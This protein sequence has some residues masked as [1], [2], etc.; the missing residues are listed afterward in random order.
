MQY[1]MGMSGLTGMTGITGMSG[2]TGMTGMTGLSGLTGMTGMSGLTSM[3]GMGDM[4]SMMS[5]T[6]M[7]QQY[8]AMMQMMQNLA[9]TSTSATGS[10]GTTTDLSGL[11]ASYMGG[12]AGTDS[13]SSLSS[14]YSQ[15]LGTYGLSTGLTSTD[16]STMISNYFSGASL[17]TGTSM[18]STSYYGDLSSL[19]S[20][21]TGLTATGSTSTVASGQGVTALLAQANSMVGLNENS[22]TAA[23]NQVTKE[24]GIN[25]A[26]TPWC[27]AWAMNLLRDNGVLDLD[28]L[29]NRNYCPTV[30]SWGKTEGI[31]KEGGQYSPQ[32][33]DA[34]LF[35]WDKDG[36][37]DHIGIVE[38]VVNGQVYTIEGNS[39]NSVK[40]NSY[41]LS[42]GSIDGY[43]ACQEQT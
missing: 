33:G 21:S 39:S 26:T 24:S 27:A 41:S 40:K 8:Q 5:M 19:L 10:L 7:Q 12:T 13:I 42:S 9:G 16:L 14:Y 25:C 35:D 31:W 22:D 4:L 36:T 37:A 43:L 3:S 34:I 32:P 28:G 30:K 38:K 6:M 20:G 23:I 15:Q 17:T 2:L 1:G 18:A 29:S 11:L